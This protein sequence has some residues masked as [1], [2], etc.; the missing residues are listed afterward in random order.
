MKNI[1]ENTIIPKITL[2]HNGAVI[3]DK[4]ITPLGVDTDC[5]D[6]AP[7]TAV[8]PDVTTVALDATATATVA[9]IAASA[10]IKAFFKKF[11]II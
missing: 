8:A 9:D 4:T 6:I 2:Y 5:V 10:I 7:E 3:L 1:I 11:M